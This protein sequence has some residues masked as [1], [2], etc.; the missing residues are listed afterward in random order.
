MHYRGYF[1]MT[2]RYP[3]PEHIKAAR[4]D[5]GLTQTEAAT[6]VYSTCRAWQYWEAGQRKMH[7]AIW[8]YFKR[9]AWNRCEGLEVNDI[10]S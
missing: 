4:L 3:K 5:A 7:P 6:L 10:F 8:A 9:L 1:N 2:T